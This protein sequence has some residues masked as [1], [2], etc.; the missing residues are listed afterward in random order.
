MRGAAS[1]RPSSTPRQQSCR[2]A[3]AYASPSEWRARVCLSCPFCCPFMFVSVIIINIVECMY[4]CA[5][6]YAKNFSSYKEKKI[7]LFFRP[8]DICSTKVQY[9]AH[10]W[11]T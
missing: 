10:T 5:L 1:V 4:A 2:G 8:L 11:T 3:C 6:V 9:Y 7:N